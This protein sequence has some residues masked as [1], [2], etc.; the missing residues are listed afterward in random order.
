[1]LALTTGCKHELA[2]VREL[3]SPTGKYHAVLYTDTRGGAAGGTCDQKIGVVPQAENFEAG[4]AMLDL[5]LTF[6]VGCD[7]RVTV[8][9]NSDSAMTIGYT[10]VQ[11]VTTY[12][13]PTSRDGKVHF[14]FV[15]RP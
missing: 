9:W 3:P 6:S 8:E 2:P 14:T 13:Q 12:Q 11:G 5:F 7:S 15:P 4:R 1:M 10:L